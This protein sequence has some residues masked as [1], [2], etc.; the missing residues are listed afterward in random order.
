MK[1]RQYVIG[2]DISSKDFAVSISTEPGIALYG[3]KEFANNLEGFN[4]LKAWLKQLKVSPKDA[5]IVMEATG[6]YGE[7]LCYFLNKH[8]YTIAVEQPL[9]VKRAFKTDGHKTDAVDSL[10]IAEYTLRFY[11]EL[12]IW[13][14]RNDIVEKMQAIITTRELLLKHKTASINS[15]KALENKAVKTSVAMKALRDSIKML[16][17]KINALEKEMDNLIDLNP[18]VRQTASNLK[19][20]KG[21]SNLLAANMFVVTNGFTSEKHHKQLASYLKIAPLQ[22]QSGSSVYKKPRKPKYGPSIMRK[23][24]FLSALSAAQHDT[25]F[26]KYNQ[27]KLAEGKEKMLIYNNIENKLIKLMCAMIRDQKPFIENYHSINPNFLIRA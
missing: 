11:D 4:K 16:A 13:E 24:L 21:V 8:K 9:K 12:N 19:T 5:I 15:L 2:I 1:K 10:Q 27:R 17:R 22:Y 6:V 7:R 20:I 23:L 14:P 18:R 26:K 25:A 3:P